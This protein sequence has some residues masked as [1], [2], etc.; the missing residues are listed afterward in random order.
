M[1]ETHLPRICSRILN[2]DRRAYRYAKTDEEAHLSA[3]PITG[4]AG[5]WWEVRLARP[6]GRLGGSRRARPRSIGRRSREA[7]QEG[8]RKRLQALRTAGWMRVD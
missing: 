8:Y 4:P 2:I 5:P 6:D 7:A 3:G 1:I